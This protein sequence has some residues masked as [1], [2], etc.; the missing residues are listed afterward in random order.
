M[1]ASGS[2]AKKRRPQAPVVTRRQGPPWLTIGAVVVILALVAGIFYVVFSKTQENTAAQ[3][4][5]APWTPSESNQDPST[6]IPGIYIGASTPA[7]AD[8]PAS[9]VEY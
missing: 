2:S 7:S 4:A 9:Y 6:A 1:M 8:T 3:D 5:L